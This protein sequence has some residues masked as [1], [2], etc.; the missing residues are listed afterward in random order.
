MR[1][2]KTFCF[3]VPG[4]RFYILVYQRGEYGVDTLQDK[5]ARI[6]GRN[7]KTAVDI[8]DMDRVYAGIL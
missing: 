2:E 7:K 3:N 8:S 4:N 1:R 5:T 6:R